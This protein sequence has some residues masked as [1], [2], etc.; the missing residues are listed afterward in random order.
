MLPTDYR[1]EYNTLL[2][3]ESQRGPGGIQQLVDEYGNIIYHGLAT[4]PEFMEYWDYRRLFTEQASLYQKANL[5]I[6]MNVQSCNDATTNLSLF[7]ANPDQ[8][9]EGVNLFTI[10]LTDPEYG[11]AG[12]QL[13]D[14]KTLVRRFVGATHL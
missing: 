12:S 5:P 10:N 14:L 3:L 9:S 4:G 8:P 6:D 13:G 7:M 2:T 11:L 1:A